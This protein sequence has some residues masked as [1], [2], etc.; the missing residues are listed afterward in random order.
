MDHVKQTGPTMLG[1]L[2]DA[3]APFA[4]AIRIV[5]AHRDRDAGEPDAATHS[6]L[7]R[8]AARHQL[9]RSAVSLA[10][11]G[12]RSLTWEMAARLAE[13]LGGQPAEWRDLH[14]QHARV[15]R[16]AAV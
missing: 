6:A 13:E 10:M 8:F 15:P 16:A 14:E 3:G 5:L 9:N 7:S 4:D 1:D 12:N 11:H 2:L